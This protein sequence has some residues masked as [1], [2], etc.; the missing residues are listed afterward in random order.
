L[1]NKT[2]AILNKNNNDRGHCWDD[3]NN[4]DS[5][6]KVELDGSDCSTLIVRVYNY[7]TVTYFCFTV[8]AEQKFLDQY[9]ILV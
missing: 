6:S 1:C 4:N 3:D 7:F 2:N 8:V 5:Y 9:A